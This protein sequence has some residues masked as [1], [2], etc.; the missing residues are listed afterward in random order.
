LQPDDEVLLAPAAAAAA[1]S[2]VDA[3][4]A[5]KREDMGIATAG[6]AS[7][8]IRSVAVIGMG[9]MGTQVVGQHAQHGIRS[10]IADAD[11][12]LLADARHRVERQWDDDS[13]PRGPIR[14]PDL[15]ALV[16]P[17]A[18]DAELALCDLLLETI[19]E[20]PLAKQRLYARLEPLLAIDTP[21]ASNTSTIPVARLASALARPDRF[22][23]LHFFH[24]VGIRPLL[25]V[26]RGPETSAAMIATAL[27]YARAIGKTPIVVSD[28]PGFL[29][30]RLLFPYLNEGLELL[31]DGVSMIEVEQAATRFGMAMGPLRL[32]DEIGLETTLR[33]GMVLREAYPDR[34]V[35]SPLLIAM[36]KAGRKGRKSGAG[37]FDYPPS[38]A[39]GGRP[40]PA[41]TLIAR[42]AR[43]P[44]RL[45]PAAIVARLFLPMV[46]EATRI[47]EEKRVADPRDID[48]GVLLGLGFP[49]C[50][51]GLVYWADT[52]GLPRLLPLLERLES[53]GPRAHPTALLRELVET[54]RTLGSLA[55][56]S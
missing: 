20:D 22:C 43:T 48:L 44:Q 49:A 9:T 21:L 18:D 19:V 54:G 26:V 53:M 13:G 14:R 29:V 7:R 17:A 41:A 6:E 52:V 33:C 51:G 37:F 46:L 36:L 35:A 55:G 32:L 8:P 47:L 39:G 27:G 31:L 2:Y 45:A 4:L 10:V 12:E 50:R 28:G 11:P 30:N 40:L 38:A 56:S 5:W 16:H 3:L 42:W 34:V 24:P 1:E 23:G 15:D 25:E